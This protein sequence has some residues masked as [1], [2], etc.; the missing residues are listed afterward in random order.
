MSTVVLS[1][2]IVDFS[3][4]ARKFNEA[5]A[6]SIGGGPIAKQIAPGI[7]NLGANST[8]ANGPPPRLR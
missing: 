1:T 6:Y 7:A 4:E 8:L 5:T 3:V 2:R